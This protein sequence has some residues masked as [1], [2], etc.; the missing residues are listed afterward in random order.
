MSD[1][2]KTTTTDEG[3]DPFAD[4]IDPDTLGDKAPGREDD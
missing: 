1:E 2:P 4:L 3:E